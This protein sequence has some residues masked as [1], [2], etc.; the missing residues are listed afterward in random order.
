MMAY[1]IGV[2]L[3]IDGQ[4]GMMFKG[5]IMLPIFDKFKLSREKL[6]YISDTTSGPVNCM[7]PLNA[8]GAMLI[9][10]IGKQVANGFIEGD[11][12]M[13]LLGS[14]KFQ[15][16]NIFSLV[17]LLIVIL[18]GKDF[19]PMKKAELRVQTTGKVLD[20]GVVPLMNT[21]EEVVSANVR[22]KANKRNMIIP[23]VILIVC[24]FAGLLISGGGNITQGDGSMSIL[25]AACISLIYMR[26]SFT[27]QKL[28]TAEEF[29]QNLRK[30]IDSM[31]FLMML[32]V[33][34]LAISPIISRL[35]TGMFL[36]GLASNNISGA[37]A[38]VIIFAL[39][40]MIS[41]ST[42]TSWGTFSIMMPIGI[43][44]A[45]AM[46]GDIMLTIGAVISGGMFGDHCSPISD[47]TI[48]SSTMSG[49]DLMSHT[50]TQLPYAI[51]GAFFT[52]VM[53]VVMGQV[54]R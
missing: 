6:A 8:W 29:I 34:A 37:F 28:M 23:L 53:F 13:L 5:A 27:R 20:D 12:T 15:F 26:I 32:L 31:F 36:A 2:V 4:M 50:K 14:L 47:S 42:G 3:F 49:T 40:V 41:F 38:P 35:G 43:P 44:M 22:A 10:L 25:Y 54:L 24:A 52:A 30:G 45:A 46:G 51:C 17:L 11:P 19:G 16:Y 18:S 48:L 21:E 7:I 33:L 1:L 39:G 9:A